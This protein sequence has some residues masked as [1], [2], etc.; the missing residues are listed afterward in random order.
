MSKPTLNLNSS[1]SSP[2]ISRTSLSLLARYIALSSEVGILEG[3]IRLG[4][5][6]RNAKGFLDLLFLN[7]TRF[8]LN[9]EEA[10]H[11]VKEV[12]RRCASLLYM[13]GKQEIL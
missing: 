9:I 4:D 1:K 13:I 3:E 6:Y 2:I 7:K 11:R 8:I 10:I 5:L 12:L